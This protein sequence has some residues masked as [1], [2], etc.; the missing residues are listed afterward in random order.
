MS[1]STFARSSGSLPINS[2]PMGCCGA[3]WIDVA[4]KMVSI[5]VVKTVIFGR[6]ASST[7]AIFCEVEDDLRVG[8][9]FGRALGAFPALADLRVDPE[10]AA[11]S[12]AA[13]GD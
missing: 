7:A 12:R 10:V 2:A 6:G 5:R 4:P 8:A 3:I 13:A 9:V 11:L 1:S